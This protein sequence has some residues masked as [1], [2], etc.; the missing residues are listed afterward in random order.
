MARERVTSCKSVVTELDAAI[1]DHRYS[2]NIAR[3]KAVGVSE[4][5]AQ[6]I[7]AEQLSNLYAMRANALVALDKAEKSLNIVYQAR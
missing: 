1:A 6:A 5:E 4:T 3:L 7:K 2:D